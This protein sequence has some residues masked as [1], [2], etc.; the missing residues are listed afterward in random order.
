MTGNTN[1]KSVQQLF[2][3]IKAFVVLMEKSTRSLKSIWMLDIC[4][5]DL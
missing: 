4:Q 5:Y 1:S 2:S 3:P